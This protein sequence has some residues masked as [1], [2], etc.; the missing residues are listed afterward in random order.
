MINQFIFK[1]YQYNMY[2]LS[3]CVL[4][5]RNNISIFLNVIMIVVNF[6][7][8]MEMIEAKEWI[9]ETMRDKRERHER[10]QIDM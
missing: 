9:N 8:M 2:I 10:R 7:L 4:D 5:E 6:Q 3:K 1:T